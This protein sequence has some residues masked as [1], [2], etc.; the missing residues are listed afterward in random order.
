MAYGKYVKWEWQLLLDSPQWV[1]HALESAEKGNIFTKD[2]EG[3]ALRRFLKGYKAQSPMVKAILAGQDEA[4]EK[5]EGDL[6]ATQAKLE[7]IG[8]MLEQKSDD[9]EG[10]ACG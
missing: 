8:Y 7:S 1:Y 3:K 5:V 6:Q 2:A 9:K 10:D 4:D